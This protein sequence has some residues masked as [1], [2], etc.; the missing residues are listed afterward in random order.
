[1]NDHNILFYKVK[2]LNTYQTI[3]AEFDLSKTEAAKT[4][5]IITFASPS[6]VRVWA[7]YVGTEFTAVTIGPTSHNAAIK[8]GFKNVIS[9]E[10][11]SK[12][13]EAWAETIKKVAEEFK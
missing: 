4:M 10:A 5:D 1:V 3:D 6:A 13:I 11:G 8:A 12:G 7:K 9:P 2:R